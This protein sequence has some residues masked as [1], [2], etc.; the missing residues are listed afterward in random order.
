MK[1]EV[2]PRREVLARTHPTSDKNGRCQGMPQVAPDP[3]VPLCLRWSRLHS[4][5]SFLIWFNW[6]QNLVKT[7]PRFLRTQPCPLPVLQEK[8]A[9]R[10]RQFPVLKAAPP[11]TAHLRSPISTPTGEVD[12]RIHTTNSPHLTTS[13]SV[14]QKVE[15]SWVLCSVPASHL[16]TSGQ[17][18]IP[19]TETSQ[20]SFF[21]NVLSHQ[22]SA[23][24]GDD[25]AKMRVVQIS[26]AWTRW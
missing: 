20:Q 26:H 17:N 10:P 14:A 9:P 5:G 11:R 16:S 13:N 4:Q 18:S 1:D 21:P 3:K 24:T 8:A 23:K 15:V 6:Q 19:S 12:G 25:A 2:A 22:T 7:E